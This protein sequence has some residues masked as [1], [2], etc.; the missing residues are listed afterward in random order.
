MYSPRRLAFGRLELEVIHSGLL[1]TIAIIVIMTTV[2]IEGKKLDDLLDSDS[3]KKSLKYADTVVSYIN[4]QYISLN[5]SDYSSYADHLKT[6]VSRSY[7][8]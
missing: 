3:F 8:D 2:C 4:K 1:V 6:V 7:F 5:D